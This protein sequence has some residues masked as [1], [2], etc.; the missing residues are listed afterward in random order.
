MHTMCHVSRRGNNAAY[1]QDTRRGVRTCGLG[2]FAEILPADEFK[3][4]LVKRYLSLMV[5]SRK[6]Y[7]LTVKQH[8]I[9]AAL[10]IIFNLFV[11]HTGFFPWLAV[12]LYKPRCADT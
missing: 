3:H 9:T 6:P 8:F 1:H 5:G 11:V 10:N 7:K 2:G 4:Q 12:G